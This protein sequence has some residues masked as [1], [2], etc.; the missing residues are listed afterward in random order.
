MFVAGGFQVTVLQR[1]P[2]QLWC[3]AK[4][5][6]LFLRISSNI[7]SSHW[8]KLEA[9]LKYCTCFSEMRGHSHKMKNVKEDHLSTTQND[10]H[11]IQSQNILAALICGCFVS[12]CC[13]T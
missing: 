13:N 10:P 5:L 8:E 4:T 7:R 9:R 6:F 2:L 1:S 3:M 12:H 11:I